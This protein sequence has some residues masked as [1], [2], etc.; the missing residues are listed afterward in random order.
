M[1]ERKVI[2][3]EDFKNNKEE[4]EG[5]NECESWERDCFYYDSEEWEGL[6]EYR[7][8]VAKQNIDSPYDQWRLGE[9]YILNEN[10]EEAIDFLSR[11]HIKYPDFIDVQYSLLDILFKL[12]RDENDFKWIEKP[13]VIR[14]TEDILDCCYEFLRYKRKLRTIPEI[15]YGPL[16]GKGYLKFEEEDLLEAIRKDKRFELI[17]DSIDIYGVKVKVVRKNK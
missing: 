5:F 10:Y 14:L 16:I 11:L 17:G 6:V 7:K 13:K 9:A 15:Y 12:G 8:K 2:R 4:H 1:K 3:I